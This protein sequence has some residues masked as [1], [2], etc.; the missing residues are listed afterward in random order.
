MVKSGLS[1]FTFSNTTFKNYFL[2]AT[3]EILTL[4]V[5]MFRNSYSFI[6]FLFPGSSFGNLD[7]CT[8]LNGNIEDYV[9]DQCFNSAIRELFLNKFL[10]LFSS[11]QRFINQP[12]QVKLSTYFTVLCPLIDKLPA[13]S[14]DLGSRSMV[15]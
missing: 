3:S 6:W 9:V 2:T 11:Y 4:K 10:D 14:F 5:W 7:S 12:Y 15:K 8:T 13:W 1:N